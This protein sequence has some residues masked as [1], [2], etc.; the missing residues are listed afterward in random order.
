MTTILATTAVAAMLASG[1][2][3]GDDAD[4]AAEATVAPVPDSTE[5]STVPPSTTEPAATEPEVTEPEVTEPVAT[6]PEVTV[7]AEPVSLREGMT[8]TAGWTY[9]ADSFDIPLTYTIPAELTDGRWRV[10]QANTWSTINILNVADRNPAVLDAQQ[11][12]LGFTTVPAGTTVDD[13]VARLDAYAAEND[14]FSFTRDVGAFRGE[15]VTI[16]RGS[17]NSDANG[18]FSIAVSDDTTLPMATG[19][20]E[21]LVYLVPVEERLLAVLLSGH[22]LDFDLIVTNAAPI[23]ESITFV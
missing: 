21:F 1:C 4:V 23:I 3:N 13:F 9:L 7:P 6:E 15:E 10:F 22:E 18:S 8:L 12:G 19:P 16:L 14:H 11:P 5:L 17:S 20:R 2:S